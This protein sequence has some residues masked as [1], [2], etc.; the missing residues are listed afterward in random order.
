MI[1]L[2]TAFLTLGV[3]AA[4]AT[5]AVALCR[6]GQICGGGGGEGGGGGVGGGGVAGGGGGNAPP[7]GLTV[8]IT[9][10]ALTKALSDLLN[11]TRLSIDTS[12]SATPQTAKGTQPNPT[13]QACERSIAGQEADCAKMVKSAYAACIR[14]AQ[15]Q[16]V[17]IPPTVYIDTTYYSYVLFSLPLIEVGATN[18]FIPL[19]TIVYGD[20]DFSFDID[21]D[22]VHTTVVVDPNGASNVTVGL[23][24]ST[25]PSAWINLADIQSNSPTINLT[26]VQAYG[27]P[28]VTV[29]A[30]MTGLNAS[31]FLGG[32]APTNDHKS[33]DYHGVSSMLAYDLNLTGAAADLAAEGSPYVDLPADVRAQVDGQ[34]TA[35]LNSIFNAQSTH[36]ALSKALAAFIQTQIGGTYSQITA[37]QAGPGGSTWIVYYEP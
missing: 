2:T 7:P 8:T 29:G 25:S 13:Y 9:D 28:S 36:A 17:G 26:N 23:W 34:V 1:R 4:T 6:Q 20:S 21:I 31:V 27:S 32:F 35:L 18:I 24:N 19:K 30:N 12:R 16:C 11:G 22:D 33:I 10:E 5:T 3:I 14:E 37:V 15:G